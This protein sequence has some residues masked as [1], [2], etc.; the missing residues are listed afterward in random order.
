MQRLKCNLGNYWLHDDNF[1]LICLHSYAGI[2][3]RNEPKHCL[4]ERPRVRV[5][6]LIWCFPYF[7]VNNADEDVVALMPAI[8]YL[9]MCSSDEPVG[10]EMRGS[11]WFLIFSQSENMTIDLLTRQCCKTNKLS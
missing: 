3:D 10:S 7:S 4:Q 2:C 8:F 6:L 5:K 1:A 11:F 9:D